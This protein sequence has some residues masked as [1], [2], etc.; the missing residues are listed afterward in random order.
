MSYTSL[1]LGSDTSDTSSSSGV[2]LTPNS[3]SDISSSRRS[4]IP[5]PDSTDS[6][7]S[8]STGSA[9]PSASS[10]LTP[11]SAGFVFDPADQLIAEFANLTFAQKHEALKAVGD[12]EF[13]NQKGRNEDKGKSKDKP[14][15]ELA[16]W[17]ALC[18]TCGVHEDEM[19]NSIN[20]CKQVRSAPL[21]LQSLYAILTM[22]LRSSRPTTP[23][24]LTWWKP[25][26]M[27][28]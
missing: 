14:K 6:G 20:K 3:G 26:K 17:Q 4:K 28:Q 24:S 23:T 13:E 7:S 25:C 16:D 15:P 19:P 21:P 22:M 2:L 9:A 12:F 8:T 11:N 27:V 5:T 10:P 1:R 18:R